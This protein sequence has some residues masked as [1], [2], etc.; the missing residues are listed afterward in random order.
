MAE[1]GPISSRLKWLTVSQNKLTYEYNFHIRKLTFA[2]HISGAITTS[3]L[4]HTFISHFQRVEGIYMK[5]FKEFYSPE[6]TL[7]F[8]Y[9]LFSKLKEQKLVTFI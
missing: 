6:S 2:Y 3:I 5:F 1:V 4:L 7:S 8:D 9:G